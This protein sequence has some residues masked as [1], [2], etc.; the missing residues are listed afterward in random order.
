M[1]VRVRVMRVTLVLIKSKKNTSVPVT[2]S[3]V[4]Q[5]GSTLHLDLNSLYSEL[6]HAQ[7]LLLLLLP[8]GT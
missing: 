6:H 5:S 4:D 3:D 7:S 8:S 2:V 1:D